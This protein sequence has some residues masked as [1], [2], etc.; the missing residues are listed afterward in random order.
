MGYF[1]G[2]F[3][4]TY[5]TNPV[6]SQGYPQQMY[7]QQRMDYLQSMQQPAQPQPMQ[8]P[9]DLQAR[10]VTSEEEAVAA[11]VLPNGLPF[12]FYNPNNDETYIKRVD[13]Q[14]NRAD[15]KKYGRMQPQQPVQAMQTPAVQYATVEDLEA[16]R[17]EISQLRD[18][19]PTT[20]R[21]QKG[22]DAE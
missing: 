11:Q 2:G 19:I 13:P 9:G 17:G 5:V 1:N 14:T 12:L 10:I 6:Y 20:T 3:Q 15:F 4:P 18:M 21:R 7:T 8:Q 16:I 22:A